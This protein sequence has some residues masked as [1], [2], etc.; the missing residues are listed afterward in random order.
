LNDEARNLAGKR[1]D[2]ETC[3]NQL[4]ETGMK[5]LGEN[6]IGRVVRGERVRLSSSVAG[7]TQEIRDCVLGSFDVLAS[8]AV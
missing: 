4:R 6:E 1:R 7:E 5:T 2:A 3:W 8:Q